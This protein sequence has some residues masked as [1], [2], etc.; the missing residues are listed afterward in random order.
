MEMM[1]EIASRITEQV[2]QKR[3]RANIW[4]GSRF[5]ALKDFT[6]DEIGEWGENLI[7][8]VMDLDPEVEVKHG[9]NTILEDGHYDFYMTGPFGSRRV[10]QKTARLNSGPG[11]TFQHESLRLDGTCE[12]FV[13]LDVCP[14]EMYLTVIPSESICHGERHPILGRTPHQRAESK[15]YKFDLSRNIC[16]NR[17]IPAGITMRI[18]VNTTPTQVRN[19]IKDRLS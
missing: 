2:S 18:D 13:F 14:N 16:E 11:G 9:G 1:F 10:E 6:C 19:F 3:I 5:E 15:K 8:R 12:S 7:H 17:G 4:E